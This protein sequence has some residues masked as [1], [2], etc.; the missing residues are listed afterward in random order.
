MAISLDVQ[1]LENYPGVVKKITLDVSTVVPTGTEGDEKMMLIASTGAYSNITARTAI[2]SLYIMQEYVGWAKSS[3]LAGSAGKFALDAAHCNIGISLDA[4]V[5]GTF[6][7]SDSKHYYE[8]A[9][10]YNIDS[11]PKSGETIALDLQKK[12]RALECAVADAGFQLAYNNCSVSYTGGKFLI[13]S[14]SIGSSYT[15]VDRTSVSVAPAPTNDCSALL[16]FSHPVTSENMAGVSVSEALLSLDYTAGTDT[17][18]IGLNTGVQS[19]DALYITDGTNQDYFTALTVSGIDITV[20]TVATNAFD[21][22]QNDYAIADSS[23]VQILRKQDPD[24]KPYS[25]FDDVDGI[26]RFM[27]KN[28][29]NQ[30][31]FSG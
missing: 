1:D 3:G 24:V 5:S 14:G 26:L 7:H 25:Y 28:L 10:D 19:G 22:I 4:T 2:Q 11:T 6:T 15:G 8:I 29:I 9:L 31:D 16:G 23:Y 18:V 30:V 17:L 12:L 27:A 21:G 20:A 13:A